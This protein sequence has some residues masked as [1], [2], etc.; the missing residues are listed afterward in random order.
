MKQRQLVRAFALVAVLVGSLV[1]GPAR[2][3]E[4][5]NLLHNPS[6]EEGMYHVSMSNFIGDGWSYWYQGRAADDPRGWYMPEPEFGLIANRPGQAHHGLKSQRWFN[7]WA[8]HNAGLSQ[9]VKVP[10]DSWLRFS[11]WMFNWSSQK[12]DFGISES[13]HHKRVGIDPTGGVDPFSPDIVWGNLDQTMDVWVQLAV[14][15]QAKGEHVTVYVQERPEYSVKHNDVLV[16]N[17]ELVVIPAPEGPVV[18]PAAVATKRAN[19]DN[20]TPE[21]AIAIERLP[22]IGVL[23]PDDGTKYQYFKF[24]YPG[25]DRGYEINIQAATDDPNV[26]SD[27]SF[28]VYGP[29]VGKVY[30]RSGVQPGL[31]PNITADMPTAEAGTYLVQLSNANR[32]TPVE[33]RIW[34]SGRGLIGNAG[35]EPSAR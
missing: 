22:T 33:Y 8:I 18:Q 3:Q 28:R 23:P 27:V 13:V 9:R 12:D 19:V 30:A 24:E 34:L 1:A 7:T 31:T 4:T 11:I 15:A 20:S 17:A 10:A 26:L 16:D 21:Q 14:I 35:I 32:D 5:P 29:T 6:F 2:A 25:D